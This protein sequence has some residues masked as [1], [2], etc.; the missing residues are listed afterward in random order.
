MNIY[1]KLSLMQIKNDCEFIKDLLYFIKDKNYSSILLLDIIPFISLML[2]E[3][4]NFINSNI[5]NIED[6]IPK[7]KST[8]YS[9]KDIRLK[10]KLF[11]NKTDDNIKVIKNIEYIQDRYFK[12][13]DG[14]LFY[15]NIGVYTDTNKNIIG[16][17]HLAYFFCQSEELKRLELNEIEKLYDNNKILTY[18]EMQIY[19]FNYGVY[20][21]QLASFFNN[22][23][24]ELSSVQTTYKDINYNIL[25]QDFNTFKD[26]QNFPI[27]ENKRITKLYILYLLSIVNCIL[28]FLKPIISENLSVLLRIEYIIYYYVIRSLKA[29]Y[30]YLERNKLLDTKTL[31]YFENLNIDDDFLLNSEFR[32]CMMH[33]SFKNPKNNKIL[34]NED[35][36]D[37]KKP[38]FGLVESC[39]KIDSYALENKLYNK[40]LHISNILKNCLDLNLNNTQIL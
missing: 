29:L 11:E 26:N 27:D 31:Q 30:K 10:L 17:T 9:I 20:L 3:S 8:S 35:N 13:L 12:E 15:H 33:Y 40:L 22:F 16:N 21:G 1:D 37:L 19:S 7:S 6:I 2:Y 25:Y 34:L 18:K 4:S 39:L 23:L 14:N 38:F 5:I 36:I 32:S 28:Y 24:K